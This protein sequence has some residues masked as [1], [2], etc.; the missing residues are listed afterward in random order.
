MEQITRVVIAK[1]FASIIRVE[2]LFLQNMSKQVC[3][4]GLVVNIEPRPPPIH[5]YVFNFL[6]FFFRPF[7]IVKRNQCHNVC[8]SG[9]RFSIRAD[10]N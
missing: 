5:L 4:F 2:R 8:V 9:A 10:H 1:S 6:S 3:F 7:E